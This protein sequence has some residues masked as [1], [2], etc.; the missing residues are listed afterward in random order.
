MSIPIYDYAIRYCMTRRTYAFTDG[1]HLA[2]QHWW[3]IARSTQRDVIDEIRN[4][5]Q[6]LDLTQYPTIH[7][8]ITREQNA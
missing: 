3:E 4:T 1:L 2:E 7:R 5:P 6:E 8:A